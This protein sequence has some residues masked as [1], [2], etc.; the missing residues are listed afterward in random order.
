MTMRVKYTTTPW[1]SGRSRVAVAS[2]R[3]AAEARDSEHRLDRDGAP[4]RTDEHQ[5]D[6][7]ENGDRRVA[8]AVPEHDR[9]FAEPGGAEGAHVLL[10]QR[11]RHGLARLPGEDR[12]GGHRERGYGQR[13]RAQ[14]PANPVAPSDVTRRREPPEV[15]REQHDHYETQPEVRDGQ[16]GDGPGVDHSTD[17]TPARSEDPDRDPEGLSRPGSLRR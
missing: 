10:A 17:P 1:M 12:S 8:K 16:T 13:D 4:Q 5:T 7:S 11:G 3:R 9:P 2:D 6:H 14:P 15:H